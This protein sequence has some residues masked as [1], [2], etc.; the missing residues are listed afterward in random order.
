LNFFSCQGRTKD[1]DQL[2]QKLADPDIKVVNEINI[3][4]DVKCMYECQEVNNI[5]LHN[6]PWPQ[7]LK[8]EIR[9]EINMPLN[10]FHQF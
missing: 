9:N 8:E 1:Y 6:F 7:A 5:A 2:I 10:L 3:S 4:N